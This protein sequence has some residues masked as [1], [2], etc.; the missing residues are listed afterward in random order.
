MNV[1]VLKNTC[2]FLYI[3]LIFSKITESFI[4]NVNLAIHISVSTYPL[5]CIHKTELK[6]AF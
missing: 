1:T 5:C 2:V 4:M 3:F 6:L